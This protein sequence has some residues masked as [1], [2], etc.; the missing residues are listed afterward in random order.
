MAFNTT[1]MN[2][3][4]IR[5][6]LLISTPS[7]MEMLWIVLII[8]LLFGAKKIPGLARGIGK[9]MKEFKDAKEGKEKDST[10]DKK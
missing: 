7:G 2:I 9:S 6:S 3:L 4:N 8:L 5:P 10:L 1:I